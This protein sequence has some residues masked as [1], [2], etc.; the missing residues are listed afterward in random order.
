[1][2]G[3]ITIVRALAA[4]LVLA[5]V[6][7]GLPV[8][9]AATVGNPLDSWPDLIAGD[10]SDTVLIAVLAAI[11]YTAWAQ[12]ALAVLGELIAAVLRL[13]RPVRLP[14]VLAAQQHLAHALV[15]AVLAVGPLLTAAPLS[16]A[17]TPALTHVAASTLPSPQALPSAASPAR[18]GEGAAPLAADSEAAERAGTG[19][20]VETYVVT[21]HGHGPGTYWD[22]AAE[23]LGAGERW[24]EIWELNRGRQQ[25]DGQVMTDPGLLRPGWT[26][27]VPAAGHPTPP[28]A[29]PDGDAPVVVRPGDTLTGIAAAHD[30]ATW[31][32]LWDAN[33]GRTQPGHKQFTDPDHIEPG[34][35]LALPDLTPPAADRPPAT[36]TP[37]TT[38]TTVEP[39]AGAA[40]RTSTP[41]A[42][43]GAST[44]STAQGDPAATPSLRKPPPLP[45]I[46]ADP[47]STATGIAPAPDST[48]TAA[49]TDP[50]AVS[51]ESASVE[52]DAEPQWQVDPGEAR[53]ALIAAGLGAGLV[54]AMALLRW[55]LARRRQQRYRRPG[56]SIP[57]VPVTA[58]ATERAIRTATTADITWLDE[59]LR[60]LPF[61]LSRQ[62]GGRLPE[63]IAAVLDTTGVELVL[64]HPARNAPGAW[65]VRDG[66]LRWH[67][68]RDADTGYQAQ[69]RGAH[70]AP[71]PALV[72]VGVD[73]DDRTWLLDLE[74][75][76][77]IGLTG[78]PDACLDLAR[79]L[80]AELALNPWP[81]LVYLT[82]V[83]LGDDLGP[84][85]PGRVRSVDGPQQ[86][87]AAI[88]AARVHVRS[89]TEAMTEIGLGVLPGRLL[90][91]SGDIWFPEILVLS[92]DPPPEAGI[93]DLISTLQPGTRT[94][95]SLVL[96]GSNATLVDRPWRLEVTATGLLHVPALDLHLTA[97]RLTCHAGAD[98]GALFTVADIDTD[99]DADATDAVNAHAVST[100]AAATEASPLQRNSAEVSPRWMADQ[101]HDTALR[102]I[103]AQTPDPSPSQNGLAFDWLTSPLPGVD[104][105]ADQVPQ[106]PDALE[107]PP[108][109]RV[110]LRGDPGTTTTGEP[111]AQGAAAP[112][113]AVPLRPTPPGPD[114]EN[115]DADLAAWRDPGCPR[116]K[117]RLLGPVE[118]TA[119]GSLPKGR[120]RLAWNTEIVA[121]LATRPRGASGEQLA[122]DLWP[123]VPGVSGTS[124]LRQ[125]IS[126]V[127]TWLGHDPTTGA[128][129]L[130]PATTP[131]DGTTG[132]YRVNGL[133]VDADLFT[134]LRARATRRGPDGIADLHTAL[135]L[136][137]GIPF[138]RQRP[139]GY[140]WLAER[141]LDHEY[142]AMIVDVAH[143]VAAHHLA[144]GEAAAAHAAA[145]IAAQ[146]APYDDGP[147][148]DLIA[149]CDDLGQAAEAE[150]YVGRLLGVHDADGPDDLPSRT[151][152][153]LAAR[154][155][156]SRDRAGAPGRRA[157][158]N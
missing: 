157:A 21:D 107:V 11:A 129:Y 117:V 58:R 115:L 135:D 147:L 119:S 6:L 28:A 72:S 99:A 103:A 96:T 53:A 155:G 105:G 139:G 158:P 4:L 118:V 71:Y 92:A 111:D 97:H 23:R 153:A 34:W 94:G 106:V 84:L 50:Q 27:L 14:G 93:T 113:A 67:H 98:L 100:D 122:A 134:R 9:L 63:V 154:E 78:D 88:H 5:A 37:S 148:L 109:L 151:A 3:P 44:P 36:T 91:V 104:F 61:H 87:T 65:Q 74:H 22:L 31:Q 48:M 16:P 59:V 69:H 108:A 45:T 8:L 102:P 150:L 152:R 46:P 49:P 128:P 144:G 89:M 19:Q 95:Q 81:E 25:R 127:R 51:P 146:A 42:S 123:A 156:T 54:G 52:D 120:P 112:S 20:Q 101:E 33:A 68:S 143:Q 73:Q 10:L 79:Y 70:A 77:V 40:A 41:A 29:A 30:V 43:P 2:R 55:T 62:P 75:I 24:G 85:H 126:I 57:K 132:T 136:V 124:R 1:M 38:P 138:D 90:H 7:I 18:V 130:P 121:C 35:T 125:A 140:A 60:A 86:A 56:G 39:A 47:R 17:M 142:T 32:Q 83:G 66:G 114:D 145:S 82:L 141:P 110:N 76:G 131:G 137:T 26:V 133:L 13:R 64:A 80:A 12:F 116:P 15:A 149:A